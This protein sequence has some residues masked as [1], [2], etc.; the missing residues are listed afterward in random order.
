M[1][2]DQLRQHLAQTTPEAD[3]AR[4]FDPLDLHPVPDTQEIVVEFPHDFFAQWFESSVQDHFEKQVR[5]LLG[6]GHVLRYRSRTT[7][8]PAPALAELTT[9]HIDFPFGHEF[10]FEQFFTN[11]KNQFPLTTAQNVAR[12]REVRYNPLMIEGESGTGKTHLLRSMANAVSKHTDKAFLFVGDVDQLAALYREEQGASPLDVRARISGCRYF[13]LDDLHR[14]D[15]YPGL[16]RELLILFNG[17]HNARRQMVFATALPV[18]ACPAL[19]P[20]LVSRL[21]A[22][23]M[24]QLARPDL[25]VRMRFI[26]DACQQRKIPLSKSQIL[27]LAQRHQDFRSLHGMLN[28]F[29]AFRDL[30]K[31]DIT[32]AAFE[33]I[34]GRAEDERTAKVTPQVILE[35]VAGHFKLDPKDLLG[36][37][38]LQNVVLARQMAMLICRQELGLSY[39]ALGRL[40]GGKDHSTVLHSIKKIEKLQQDNHDMK[41]LVNT[42]RVSCRQKGT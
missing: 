7:A 38:R 32:E 14:L 22:G 2:K 9:A 3:L 26:Q 31:R 8:P 18:S 20:A 42:L 23:L 21:D 29:H 10:T 1:L 12:S 37:K 24:I 5:L 28:K 13:F 4:W 40:F 36:S 30:L 41:V 6:P 15:Q 34:L 27:T 33:N 25:D 39:P 16:E 19:G 17:F 35:L 11:Q